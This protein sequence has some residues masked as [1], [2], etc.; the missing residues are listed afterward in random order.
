MR[1]IGVL[2]VTL[3]ALSACT[4]SSAGR[5]PPPTG[6]GNGQPS[7]PQEAQAPAMKIETVAG[8]LEHGWDIGFLPDGKV[9]VSQRPGKLALLSSTQPG[10]TVTQV[11]ADFSDVLAVG[12]GGLMGMVLDPDFATN[13]EFITCQTYKENGQA[14]DVRLIRWRLSP[15][16]QS[17][18]RVNVMLSG[19]PV[20]RGGRH[21][22]C[23]PTIAPDGALLVGTG[24]TARPAYPQDRTNLGGKVLRLDVKTGGPAPGNPFASSQNPNEQRVYTY[25]HR[26]VQGVAIRPTS[27]QI[28][29]A[30]HGPDKN[31]EINIE[32]A[33]KNYG[34]DPSQGGTVNSYDED[35]PMTDLQRFPDAVP[36]LWESGERT[37]AVCAATFLD[38]PQWGSFN[39]SLVVTALKGSKLLLFKMD[40]TGKVQSVSVPP[41]FDDDWGRLRAARQGPDGALYVTT[42]NGSDDK[43]L[44]VTLG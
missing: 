39:G 3:T 9:L 36:A 13:R 24:D 41:E 34:W 19:L 25:G 7:T 14:V 26:N 44:R 11:Q 23:R 18:Q 35:V 5:V 22:G 27:Q 10:A 1:R 12:E 2:L 17:A 4:E 6:A 38:G 20:A 21:S 30:E 40:D 32:Y 31:D 37:E 33:G 16:G 43:L 29:T 28:I 8:D 42:S 15:D